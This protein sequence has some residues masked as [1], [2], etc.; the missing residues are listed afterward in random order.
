M[1]HIVELEG[2]VTGFNVTEH[3]IDCICR[4]GLLKI[5]KYSHDIICQRTV[6]EKEGLSRKLIADDEHIYIYDFCTLYVLNKKSYELLGKWRLGHDL[7]S[8][9]CGIAVDDDAVYCSIRNVKIS[10]ER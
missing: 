2:I 7:S 3:C 6:F 5:D 4:K 8:D 9:I 10:R 1:E